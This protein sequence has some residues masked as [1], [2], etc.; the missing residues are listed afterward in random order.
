M[1]YNKFYLE[2]FIPEM[3][4]LLNE[5]FDAFK[6]YMDIFYNEANGILIKPLQTTGQ[7]SAA[8]GKFTSCLKQI[9]VTCFTTFKCLI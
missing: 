7:V 6:A 8:Q 5:N 1:E 3:P 2:T 4:R 9:S